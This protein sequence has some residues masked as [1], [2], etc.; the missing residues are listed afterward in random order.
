MI[1]LARRSRDYNNDSMTDLARN[2]GMKKDILLI[3]PGDQTK[4]YQDL[5]GAFTAIAPPVWLTLIADFLRRED[6]DVAIYDSNVEGWSSRTAHDLLYRFNPELVVIMAY[7]HNPSASTQTMPAAIAT[8]KDIKAANPSLP[9]AVG[10]L[11]PTVLPERTLMETSADFIVKGEAVHPIRSLLEYL[12][13]RRT[14]SEL[15]GVCARAR[16]GTYWNQPPAEPIKDLD[17]TLRGYAWDLLPSLKMYRAHNSHTIQYFRHSTRPDFA[18][19]RSPYAV[20]YTSLGCPYRCAFCCIN[21]LFGRPGIRYWGLDTVMGWIDELAQQHHVKHIRLDDELFVLDPRRVEHFCD[22]LIER[23]YDLNLWV[24]ARVDT[25]SRS[26]LKRMRSAGI[27]WI[28]LGIEAGND[29]VRRRV[30]KK[31][32]RDVE[33][34]RAIIRD[35]DINVL[36]NYMFGLPG[37][38]ESTMQQTLDLAIQL[39][40]EFANF[41]CAMAYP[42]SKLYEEWSARAPAELPETWHGFSQ[43]SYESKPLPTDHLSAAQVLAFR[44]RAFHAYFTSPA[45]LTMIREK[46]GP[47]A[48]QHIQQMTSIRLQRKLLENR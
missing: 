20:L 44:D 21:A 22:M 14:R 8:A 35:H 16:D 41:Y 31:I 39:N 48:E 27:Q 32:G 25:I 19:V 12:K 26:L 4:T 45:Y 42:G 7:G 2:D 24:Y 11:H 46:F 3:H 18:D 38:T 34:I 30:N 33:E 13:G 17:H 10:G 6:F 28:C 15:V 9:L 40:C 37:D 23:K 47:V 43:H 1:V 29:D 36:G 5:A